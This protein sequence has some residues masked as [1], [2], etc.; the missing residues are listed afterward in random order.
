M[1]ALSWMNSLSFRWRLV[2]VAIL[3]SAIVQLAAVA[4]ITFYFSQSYRSEK[5]GEYAVQANVLAASLTAAL[6]FDDAAAAR[7]YLD[8]LQAN[9][10]IAAAG[11][12][13]ASGKLVA[14]YT[15]AGQPG[16][17]LPSAFPVTGEV[18]DG[19]TLRIAQPVARSGT[20]VG[21]IYLVVE[22]KTF[23]TL[24][25]QTGGLMLLAVF[26]SLLVAVP[27]AMRLNAETARDIKTI[28]DAASRVKAGQFDFNLPATTRKD[29]IGLLTEGFDQ[30]LV[31]LRE[32]MQQERL[33]ALG[34]MS[35]GVA[36][37]INNALSPV[38]L[39]T[40]SLLEREPNL[41]PRTR[42]YL[43]TV[44][45]VVADV[46]ETV[47]RMREFSRKRQPEMT[48]TPVDLNKLAHQVIELTRAR[49]SDMQQ[50]SGAD[51]EM[52]TELA[53]DLPL[54][55]GAEGEIREALTNLIFNAADAMPNGG[56]LTVSTGADT[57]GHVGI[58]VSDTGIG[59]DEETKRR[60]FEPFFTTKGERGTGLGMAMVYG[61][62]QRHSAG[63]EIDSTVGKGT[64]VRLVFLAR[65]AAPV[66][67]APAVAVRPAEPLR[68][69]VVDDDP[70]VLDSMCTVLELDGHE[71]VVADGGQKGIDTFRAM[72]NNGKPFGLVITDLGMPHVNGNQVAQAIKEMSP[73]TPV[74]L[75]TGW[76]RRMASEGETPKHAD[77]V[78]SKPPA[79][80]ELRAALARLSSTA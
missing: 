75:L 70:S 64:A 74:I 4:V 80:D 18:F 12:Y 53:R 65:A 11:A 51:I 69:L 71:T 22:T 5:A 31:S 37:D 52:R 73:R 40:D 29:E 3:T 78:L 28:A 59:M 26:A 42:A 25:W 14:S 77:C 39:Y 47:G 10:E 72:Q 63:I 32:M 20:R 8:A 67:A 57:T 27:V 16:T 44:K 48:L 38:A 56:T 34:Q 58:A 46:T 35:S 15:R 36:H 2:V 24:L 45:R 55:M 23:G 9:T 41:S 17:L 60:C 7:E 50:Q 6:A 79:L 62:V 19:P 49:W 66:E 30:M 76:G 21:G 33:R 43:E 68:L 54:V 61:A 13:D 1:R